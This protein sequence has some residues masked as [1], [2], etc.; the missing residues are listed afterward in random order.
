MAKLNVVPA[1]AGGRL[2]GCDVHYRH[3]MVAVI[4][5]ADFEAG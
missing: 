1:L 5:L 2:I 3:V 4:I